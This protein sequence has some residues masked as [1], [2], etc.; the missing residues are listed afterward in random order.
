MEVESFQDPSTLQAMKMHPKATTWRKKINRATRIHGIDGIDGCTVTAQPTS[1]LHANQ[2]INANLALLLLTNTFLMI[3]LVVLLHVVARQQGH[4]S[5]IHLRA[6]LV[7]CVGR[8]QVKW[9]RGQHLPA[10]Q[11]VSQAW[12]IKDERLQELC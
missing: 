1:G 9:S 7:G 8:L 11:P 3:W 12:K 5:C 2:L 4:L 10:R 6:G